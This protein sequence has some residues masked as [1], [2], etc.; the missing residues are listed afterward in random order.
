MLC[1]NHPHSRR[2]CWRATI[3]FKSNENKTNINRYFYVFVI[4]YDFYTKKKKNKLIIISTHL[5][6]CFSKYSWKIAGIVEKLSSIISFCIIFWLGPLAWLVPAVHMI[7]AYVN[8]HCYDMKKKIQHWVSLM[9]K[10]SMNKHKEE[11]S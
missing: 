5:S 10:I 11:A 8:Y 1:N 7:R 3:W 9:P 6:P 4:S 2:C